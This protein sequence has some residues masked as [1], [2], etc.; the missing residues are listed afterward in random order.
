MRLSLESKR[1]FF[2]AQVIAIAAEEPQVT[3]SS[4]LAALFVSPPI[5]N[6]CERTGC[7]TAHLIHAFRVSDSLRQLEHAAALLAAKGIEFGSR[8]HIDSLDGNLRPMSHELLEL[9]R[10]LDENFASPNARVTVFDILEAL[11]SQDAAAGA[12]LS[13][14]GLTIA[15]LRATAGDDLSAG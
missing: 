4:L 9:I 15:E 3:K 2:R 12:T 14:S 10:A 1:A 6:T 13:A 7:P 5:V 11:T 8:T